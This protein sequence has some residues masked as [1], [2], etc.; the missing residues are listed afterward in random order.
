MTFKIKDYTNYFAIIPIFIA[1]S[2]LYNK[3][4]D[5]LHKENFIDDYDMIQK[6]LLTD[7][8]LDTYEQGSI[9]GNKT[10][11]KPI[12]W[13]HMN[14]E[15][16]SRSWAS[17]GSR[18]SNELNQP[19]L[20]LTVRSIITQ[21]S[22]SFHIC[23]IDDDSFSKLLPTWQ[24]NMTTLANPTLKYM[25]ELGLAKVLHKYGGIIVPPSFLCMR[26]L[27][28][29]YNVSTR[30]DKL[31]VA[32]MVNTNITSTEYEFYP[33]CHFMG[34]DKECPILG[35][36]IDFMARTMSTDS[37]GQQEFLGEW[38]RWIEARVKKGRI[39]IVDGTLIGTKTVDEQPVLLDDL[40]SNNYLSI[41]KK[42]YG[43]Y[44]PACEILK[45]RKYE[46]FSR[47]SPKQ[48][49]ESNTIIGKYLMLASRP[50]AKELT[51]DKND[52]VGPTNSGSWINYWQVPSGF[53]LWGQKPNYLGN[54]VLK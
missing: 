28:N 39:N 11:K 33:N 25:R 22:D 5:K 10:S 46:W 53:G 27:I 54:H 49:L 29:M 47:L 23:L 8:S 51:I 38:N 14:Y 50:N 44:I 30:D 6:F 20:F 18:S 26:N 35:E 52:K 17:F 12:L 45:R 34:A 37:T 48:A 13:L 41:Y 4:E 43:I 21:C 9:Q 2:F 16:N 36:F 24:V 3:Y 40:M 15:Y 19:Y 42:T 7:H 32:E 1:V 31:F